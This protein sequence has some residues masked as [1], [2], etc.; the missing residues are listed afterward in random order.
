MG[1]GWGWGGERVDMGSY[2]QQPATGTKIQF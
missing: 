2:E 1:W